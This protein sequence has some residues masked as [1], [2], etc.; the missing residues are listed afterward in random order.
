[1]GDFTQTHQKKPR[2]LAEA[3]RLAREQQLLAQIERERE[4]L[5]KTQE[6]RR[7]E[8]QE[9]LAR[10]ETVASQLKDSVVTGRGGS[11]SAIQD[12][13]SSASKTG[14]QNV[15]NSAQPLHAAEVDEMWN[16]RLVQAKA[17][18]QRHYQRV[19]RRNTARTWN[20]SLSG[21]FFYFTA[22]SFLWL[23]NLPPKLFQLQSQCFYA[24]L[25]LAAESRMILAR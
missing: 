6:Q 8:R 18:R 22:L 7:R 17:L 5:R 3:R 4:I 12:A 1:M 11:S 23:P 20:Q 19:W 10:L 16:R 14:P 21:T 2:Q 15:I 24:W 13:A 9:H 25:R